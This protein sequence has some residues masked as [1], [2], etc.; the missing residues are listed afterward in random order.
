MVKLSRQTVQNCKTLHENCD[1]I[2]EVDGN[3]K[4]VDNCL[5]LYSSRKM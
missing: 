4:I 1:H 3:F 2:F 5:F